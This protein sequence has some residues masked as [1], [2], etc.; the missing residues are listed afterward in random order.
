MQFPNCYISKQIQRNISLTRSK[1]RLQLFRLTRQYWKCVLRQSSTRAHVLS[2]T[3]RQSSISLLKCN[4]FAEKTVIKRFQQFIHL[5]N[6]MFPCTQR[7]KNIQDWNQENKKGK[8]TYQPIKVDLKK[9]S[10]K[11]LL[12]KRI[13]FYEGNTV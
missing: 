11:I 1:S 6:I 9:I 10:S 7:Y 12:K 13:S 5:F 2:S 4:C 3:I 8:P